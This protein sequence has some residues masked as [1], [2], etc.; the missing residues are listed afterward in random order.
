MGITFIVHAIIMNCLAKSA[1]RIYNTQFIELNMKSFDKTH[2]PIGTRGIVF[3]FD[4]RK[5]SNLN[6]SRLQYHLYFFLL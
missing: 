5:K 2:N 4:Y 6:M 1:I 3:L